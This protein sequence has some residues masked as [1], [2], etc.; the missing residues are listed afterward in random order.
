MGH[1]G[2][3]ENDI[4]IATFLTQT[5]T[6]LIYNWVILSYNDEG[7][8]LQTSLHMDWNHIYLF[9]IYHYDWE[10]ISIKVFSD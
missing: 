4:C 6:C 9:I 7:Y 1:D 5:T 3:C 10:F 8:G 2:K